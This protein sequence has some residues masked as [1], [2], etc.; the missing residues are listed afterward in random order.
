MSEIFGAEA[1]TPKEVAARI[2]TVGVTKANLPLIPLAAL[3][4]LAGG[5]IG[6]GALFYTL[7][8]SDSS[9][10]FAVQRLLG[11][12]VFSLGLILVV[13]AGA[14]LFTGNN[15]MVM[16]WVDRQISTKL[17]VRNLGLVYLTNFFGAAGLALLVAW[18]GQAKMNGGA[19]GATAIVIA[20]GK[21]SLGFGEAF[22]RGVLCNVLVCLAVWL[23]MAGKSVTDRIVAVIFPITA[24]VAAGFEHCVA[25]MYFVPLGL[26]LA[27]GNGPTELSW[28]G[29]A[30]HNLLPVTLGNLVGGAGMVGMVYWVIYCRGKS[31]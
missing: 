27:E 18:S 23:A 21:C 26:I 30:V 2:E 13:V 22:F 24:F 6:L 31:D 14:E 7:V 17:I 12:T 1:Y 20:T 8:V 25:N 3:G 29:F 16:A 11:G 4:V 10:S 15:L 19:V 5:F 9:L 28:S